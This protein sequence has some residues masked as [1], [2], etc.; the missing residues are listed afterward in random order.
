MFEGMRAPKFELYASE[1][2]DVSS[3]SHSDLKCYSHTT[4]DLTRLIVC[5]PGDAVRLDGVCA[6]L[7]K[8]VSEK[9]SIK[10]MTKL[11]AAKN[12]P[13]NLTPIGA[14]ETGACQRCGDGV[15]LLLR[16]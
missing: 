6:T 3:H 14:G 12:R 8:S 5:E 11:T 2:M 4:F 1:D 15:N 7:K 10:M 16:A 13:K 9:A